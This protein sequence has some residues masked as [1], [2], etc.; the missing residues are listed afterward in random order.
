MLRKFLRIILLAECLG[1]IPLAIFI[2]RHDQAPYNPAIVDKTY[3]AVR[4]KHNI[5]YQT[6]ITADDVEDFEL[7]HDTNAFL[8]KDNFHS[9][10]SACYRNT[11]RQ[12]EK[13]EVLKYSDTGFRTAPKFFPDPDHEV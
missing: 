13:G 6:E 8:L 1:L 12:I 7:S 11:N 2:T 3:L 5:P 9:S 10:L 4:A